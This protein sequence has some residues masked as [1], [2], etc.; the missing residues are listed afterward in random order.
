MVTEES[1]TEVL[2]INK[3]IDIIK[4][5]HGDIT[6]KDSIK[7]LGHQLQ[8]NLA[9]SKSVDTLKVRINQGT[10]RIWQF[11]TCP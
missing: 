11:P 10:G 1:K 2:M 3:N 6:P 5:P 4:S 7:F 8:R 9:I